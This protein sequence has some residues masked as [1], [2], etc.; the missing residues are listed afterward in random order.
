[1]PAGSVPAFVEAA[2]AASGVLGS[3][4]LGLSMSEFPTG[5]V[6]FLFT[7]LEGSTRLWEEH[8]EAMKEALARHDVIVREAV[9]GRGGRVIK[10][11]GDGLH[12]VFDTAQDAAAAA[13]G[14]QRALAEEQWDTTGPLRVR[15][16]LHTGEAEH[17]AGDYYGP[18][19]NRAARVAGAAHGGQ[20]LMSHATEEVLRDHL[21]GE[22]AL[23]DLGEHRLRD[24][25]RAER[26]FQVVHPDLERDF[27]RLR[28]LEAFPGNLPAQVTSFVGRV[29]E[30]AAVAEALREARLVTLTGVGG[31]GKTRLAIQ[32]AAEVLPDDRDG[33]WLCELAAAG[34]PDAMVQVVAAALG[35]QS[36]PGE[37]LDTR[38]REFL[39]DRRALVVFDN[40]EHLLDAMSHLAEG[41][42]RECPEVRILATSR[43][44]LGIGGERIVRVRSLPIG[45]PVRDGEEGGESDAVRLF[46]ERAS[47]AEPDFDLD[48][49]DTRIVEDICRRLD[50]IPL[51]IELAAARVVAMSPAEILG[52]L[53]ERFRLLTGG[54]RTAVERHQ[55]LRATV[56][57]SYALLRPT[58]QVVFA[59]L[60]VFPASFNA[61]A[62]QAVARGEGVQE[63]DVLDALTGLV[64][65]SMVNT[66]AGAAGATRY[67]LLETMRQYARE[68]LDESG[69]ADD[70]RRAHAAHYEEIVANYSQ[71]MSMGQQLPEMNEA[72]RVEL[73]NL[74][75]AVTWALD[76]DTPGDGDVALR[77][78]GALA[79]VGGTDRRAAGLIAHADR[80]LARAE[81]SSPDLRAGIL[82][83]MASDA[84]QLRGDPVAAEELAR[85]A[86]ADGPTNTGA[87]AMTYTTLSLCA[88]IAGDSER[89]L[90]IL[91]EGQRATAKLGAG[92]AHDRAFFEIQIAHTEERRGDT[93]AARAHAAE[94]VRLARQAQF[95]FRLAQTLNVWADLTRYDDPDT[96][97][98]ALAEATDV[99]PKALAAAERGRTF[100]IRAQLRAQQGD[101]RGAVALLH[102][103]LVLWGSEVPTLYVATA[104]HRAAKILADVDETRPAAVI[105]GAATTGPHA[106][107]TSLLAPRARE[108]LNQ[109][110]QHLRATLGAD[111]Y[112]TEAAR[113]AAMS[114]DDTLRFLRG[115]V[116]SL[117]DSAHD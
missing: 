66:A 67:Q 80:L 15:M 1:M 108:E 57:W 10:T 14:A 54:R 69:D 63:W 31:V 36:Y 104:T 102:Q 2:R 116:E 111:L 20:I 64:N 90:E 107:L 26:V 49:T 16:G 52:L 33:A 6:T 61:A 106:S 86:L 13:I 12:A 40:C 97:E 56:D 35:V 42:V 93:N 28:S 76:S 38:V 3:R 39:R 79:G 100:L 65:K 99:A 25:S 30:I 72:L 112:D 81:T 50:G 4:R 74:R 94:A 105:A 83:G 117:V 53:D 24:L 88:G 68:R 8:P 60:G 85:R 91:A 95:P 11:T 41:I 51:A 113:G 96:A 37:P 23:V 62:A 29:D 98:A 82:A 43:E 22:V 78:A 5:T 17:R 115:T 84:L 55:T 73:D 70:C 71:A 27:P 110:I 44:P 77:I 101:A 7:D 48:E 21:R 59:R 34:D 87:A 114:S 32:T 18:V 89:Q 19:L 46:V 75:A 58:E 47:G 9:E 109:T 103:A 45:D 92:T